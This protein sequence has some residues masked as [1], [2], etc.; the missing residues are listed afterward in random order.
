MALSTCMWTDAILHVST[1]SFSD[2]WPEESVSLGG[3]FKV[4]PLP[5]KRS[6][7]LKPLFAITASPS[8]NKSSNPHWEVTALSEMLPPNNSETKHIA[9]EGVIPIKALNVLWF[10]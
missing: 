7:M 1:W 2:N 8:S 4:M 9:P 5:S 10:L 6:I 3:M